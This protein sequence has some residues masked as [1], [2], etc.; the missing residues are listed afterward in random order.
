MGRIT[1][2]RQLGRRVR[3]R[4]L[5]EFGLG[6]QSQWE[7]LA[8]EGIVSAGRGTFDL[9]SVRIQ[10]YR[11]PDGQWIGGKLRIGN[12]TSIGYVRVFLSGEHR[13]DWV[14]TY[15]FRTLNG[16]P[17]AGEENLSRGDVEIGNDCWVCIESTVL[18]GVTIGDGAVVGACSVV[19][20]DVPPYAIV[21]GNPA[22]VVGQRFDDDTV[23]WLLD[24]KW[25]DWPED[26][27]MASLD[28]LSA[29]PPPPADR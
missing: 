22:R 11:M 8:A 21:A 6:P 23:A 7:R 10:E 5:R 20:K 13:K 2:P 24:L 29:P 4:V 27:I 14:T 19:T 12:Y 17:G 1:L 9:P 3:T 26:K 18:S 28:F 25:W 15:P 16:L